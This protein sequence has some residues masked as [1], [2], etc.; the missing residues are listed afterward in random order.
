MQ[1]FKISVKFEQNGQ[2]SH[3][4]ADTIGYLVKR[5]EE[6]DVIEGY[7]EVQYPTSSDVIRYIKG[8]YKVET[9]QLVFLQ[10]VND[11]SLHP[12]MYTFADI[13]KEG[14]WDGYDFDT[15]YFYKGKYVG[16]ARIEVTEITD[17]EE[18]KQLA[19]ETISIFERKASDATSMNGQFMQQVSIFTDFL[20]AP[21]YPK[22]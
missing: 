22:E 21:Y 4:D 2:W 13:Q 5:T 18:K 14:F 12:L 20:E 1:L 7:V 6:S 10:M 3:R 11:P 9:K 19:E 8:L 16:H 15:G 17:E